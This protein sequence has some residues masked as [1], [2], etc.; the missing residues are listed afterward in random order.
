MSSILSTSIYGSSTNKGMGGLLSGLDTDDLVT[1]MT[2]GTRSKINKQYQAKQKLLYR[3]EAYREISTKLIALNSKYFSYSSGSTTNILS[4]KFFEAYTFKSS[5][6]YVNVT[7]NADSIKNFEIDSITS[8]ASAASLTSNKKV[9]NESFSTYDAI[10]DEIS[11][12][13]GETFSI[14]YNDRTYSLTVDKDFKGNTFEDVENQLNAQLKDSDGNPLEF[15]FYFTEEADGKAKLALSEGAYL[16]AASSEFLS[17]LKMKTGEEN[18]SLS[19]D[20]IDTTDLVRDQASI[21]KDESSYITFE[22]N[23]VVKQIKL[24]DSIDNIKE[25]GEYLTTKL[26]EAYGEGKILVDY[27]ET[28]PKKISF[29]TAGDNNILKVS[30]ISKDL[31]KLTGL[32]SGDSNRIKKDAAIGESGIEGLTVPEGD[33]GE[34][35]ITINNKTLTF[36]KTATLNDIIK[37]INDDADMKVTV[38]YSS[39]TDTLSVVADETGSHL[40]VEIQDDGEGSLA[41]ALF[42]SESNWNVK[43][44]QDTVLEYKMNGGD[45]ITITRSTANFTIDDISIEL[46]KNAAG[47][48]TTDTPV[49]FDVTNNV[50]EVV[51]RVKEF[52]DEYNEII[53]LINTKTSERPDSD[54]PPLTPEQQDEM[55]EDEIKNWTE[56][57]KKGILYSDSK[58]RNVLTKMRGAMGGITDV[59]SLTL[60]SIGISSAYMDTS[61]K[62]VF[63]EDKFKEKLMED[64]EE[65]ENL[66]SGAA[67]GEDGTSGIAVQLR[68]IL[69][70]NVGISGTAGLLI[71]EA[72]LDNSMT[73][74]SNYISERIEEYDDKMADLKEELEDERE[75]YWNKFTA[76][77]ESL[78]QLNSQS[79]WLTDMLGN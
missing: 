5:S 47:L 1:Q 13:A 15:N 52:V 40:G 45:P 12:L 43:E 34:Y 77:E 21:L 74:D 6:D 42:G 58:M 56:E 3:Q 9:S 51:E 23:G 20:F 18:G 11:R 44:G 25:L 76:L 48:E 73:S 27:E 66:F 10:S 57:A 50:D 31:S 75:R 26:K 36:A 67:S 37:S 79:S 7:G 60:S 41:Y 69:V 19:T 71:E 29:L 2:A 35:S 22:Y 53:T 39:T 68:E 8:V 78:N 32:K 49:T 28:D 72:G 55:T 38:S 33:D 17:V 30:S 24:D 4:S 54:Y 14:K 59:S 61:G 70:Q 63:D 16:S 64:P 46:N 65:V 62:L